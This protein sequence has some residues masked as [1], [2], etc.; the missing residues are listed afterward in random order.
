VQAIA[1]AYPVYAINA[2][3]C[4]ECV[5]FADA[6]QCAEICPVGAVQTAA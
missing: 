3:V 1:E 5:G 4:I 2:Y 6:P